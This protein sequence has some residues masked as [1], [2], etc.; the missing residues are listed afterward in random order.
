MPRTQGKAPRERSPSLLEVVWMREYRQFSGSYQTRSLHIFER[1][2]SP[3]RDRRRSLGTYTKS[4]RI[5]TQWRPRLRHLLLVELPL[6]QD[7]TGGKDQ[8]APTARKRD[9]PDGFDIDCT[10]GGIV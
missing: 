4:G 10:F 8:R 9:H 2:S 6:S 7:M 5:A 1:L 3:W